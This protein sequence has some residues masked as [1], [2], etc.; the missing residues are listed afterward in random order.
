MPR[1]IATHVPLLNDARGAFGAARV[2]TERHRCHTR[3]SFIA[4]SVNAYELR[5][6]PLPSIRNRFAILPQQS[7]MESAINNQQSQNVMWPPTRSS[8]PMTTADGRPSDEPIVVTALVTA[9]LL[10]REFGLFR[11]LLSWSPWSRP[12]V[13]PPKIVAFVS[14]VFT[15]NSTP[16]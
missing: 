8:R 15:W 1:R 14:R 13:R 3:A 9:L 4:K 7:A 2:L 5:R 11:S 16:L 10:M 6:D 12:I